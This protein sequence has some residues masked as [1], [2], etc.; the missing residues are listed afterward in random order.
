M[1][2]QFGM[3]VFGPN[4]FNVESGKTAPYM[5]GICDHYVSNCMIL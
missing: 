3:Y 5:C 4:V 1:Y 2:L